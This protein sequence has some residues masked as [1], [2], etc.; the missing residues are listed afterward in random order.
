MEDTT[1]EEMFWGLIVKP[2]KRFQQTVE[3]SFHVSKA[4]V[5]P[6]TSSGVTSIF[7]EVDSGEE[8]IVANLSH[9]N[10]SENLDLNFAEG[11]KIT[12]RSSG[13]ATVHLTGYLME[14]E[15]QQMP[16]FMEDSD[17]DEEEEEMPQLVNGAGKLSKAEKKEA[18]K[19][20]M[21][22]Q[23]KVAKTAKKA[24]EAEEE[25]DDDDEEEEDSDEEGEEDEEVDDESEEEEEE[26]TPSKKE[27]KK[28]NGSAKKQEQQPKKETAF[29]QLKG[30]IISEDIRVGK[31]PVASRGKRVG[32]YYSG[33]L[34]SNHK[35]F[36][37]CLK[38]K[39]FKFRLG[40]G[41]VIKGWDL[42]I[43]GIKVG[44]KR[45]LV[46]PAAMGYG[47]RGA[48]PDIPPNATLVF[49]VECK[50]VN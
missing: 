20:A 43:E 45:R 49:E 28:E 33:K 44:G 46:I 22:M 32:M 38:G 48:M 26:K 19:M 29:R 7:V 10:L 13:A 6:S 40:A 37:S 17:D 16:D 25:S 39:P 36:D 15:S 23:N 12:F 34:K 41:E 2:D 50:T 14:D 1:K 30:G 31:G 9:P 8:F 35:Q 18:I 5:D 24:S 21:A 3:Q 42:G 27:V 4:C 11:D 47:A